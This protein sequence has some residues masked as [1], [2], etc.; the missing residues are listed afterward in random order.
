MAKK[1]DLRVKSRK[2]RESPYQKIRDSLQ[3]P[4]DAPDEEGAE[5]SP[6]REVSRKSRR[7]RRRVLRVISRLII[8]AALALAVYL[9]WQNWD[10]L[11][12]ANLIVWIEDTFSGKGQNGS[13]PV[14]LSGGTVVGMEEMDGN[15][16]VLTDT[17]FRMYRENGAELLRRT[18]GYS[19]AQLCTAGEYALIAELGGSRFRLETRAETVLNVTNDNQAVDENNKVAQILDVPLGNNILAADVDENGRMAFVTAA[20]QSFLSEVV[21]YSKKGQQLFRA[22]DT[23]MM[24]VDVALSPDGTQVA[25]VGVS[26]EGGAVTSTLKVYDLNA[27]DQAPWEHTESETMLLGVDYFAGGTVA[28]VGDNAVWV[29]KPNGALFEK[30]E[31]D[32][33]Q[34]AGF[35]IGEDCAALVLQKYGSSDGGELMMVLPTGD[36]SFTQTFDEAFRQ[37]APADNGVLLLVAG[38]LYQ[39]DLKGL[40]TPVEVQQDCQRVEKIGNTLVTLG[41]AELRRVDT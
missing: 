15:L 1:Q 22:E 14:E 24:A 13:F 9:V 36:V 23:E 26:A 5:P 10:K 41:L 19:N 11:S 34:L 38:K 18:L 29:A 35:A 16:A 8:L 12:P 2:K 20:S 33:R 17:E 39:T 7:R 21:V 30:Q 3:V 27:P 37:V 4:A 31:Y 25:V 32:D 6:V 40:G 28:A